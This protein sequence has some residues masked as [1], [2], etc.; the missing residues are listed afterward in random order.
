MLGTGVGFSSGGR[1]GPCPQEAYSLV[2][3][4]DIKQ[5]QKHHVKVCNLNYN[6]VMGFR[7]Q[8]QNITFWHNEYFKLKEF[9]KWHV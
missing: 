3:V 8:P 2:G 7:A 9:D 4:A 6:K 5:Q 1:D